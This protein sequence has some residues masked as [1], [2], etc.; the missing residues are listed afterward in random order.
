MRRKKHREKRG[1]VVGVGQPRNSYVPS[2]PD[3]RGTSRRRR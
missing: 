3:G 1:N 2:C